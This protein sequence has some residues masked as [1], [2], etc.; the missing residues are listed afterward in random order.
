MLPGLIVIRS[1]LESSDAV[2]EHIKKAGREAMAKAKDVFQ[3]G[4]SESCS[5][6]RAALDRGVAVSKI[7]PINRSKIRVFLVDRGNCCN[8]QPSVT[9][10]A[11]IDGMWWLLRVRAGVRR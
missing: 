9:L 11:I 6:L 4:C 1:S 8:E 5:E 10:N 3:P 7:V 2:H